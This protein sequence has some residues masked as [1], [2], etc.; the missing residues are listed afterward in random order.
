[1]DKIAL[2][3]K[4]T[5]SFS[6]K[7]VFIGVLVAGVVLVLHLL[8]RYETISTKSGSKHIVV[9]FDRWTGN[10]CRLLPVVDADRKKIPRDSYGNYP[11]G[12]SLRKRYPPC[13]YAY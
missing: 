7:K 5:R 6:K 12:I 3:Q 10:A 8:T 9:R 2:L 1:M 11:D 13:H 4:M